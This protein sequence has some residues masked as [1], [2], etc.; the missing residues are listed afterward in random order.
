MKSSTRH[1]IR[2]VGRTID[3]R[4]VRS[5]AAR[6]LRVRVGP[7]GVEVVQPIARNGEDVPEFLVSNGCWIVE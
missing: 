2:I 7:G 5:K 4:L 1:R 3:Y 6:K